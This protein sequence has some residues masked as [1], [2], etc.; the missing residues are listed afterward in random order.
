MPRPDQ[1]CPARAYHDGIHKRFRQI[2]TH[3]EATPWD[4]ADQSTG[5]G[6]PVL[7]ASKRRSTLQQPSYGDVAQQTKMSWLTFLMTSLL[8]YQEEGVSE[9]LSKDHLCTSSHLCNTCSSRAWTTLPFTFDGRMDGQTDRRTKTCHVKKW[10]VVRPGVS[11]FLVCDQRLCLR[12]TWYHL[13]W[14]TRARDAVVRTYASNFYM[15]EELLNT[16]TKEC[17]WT[18]LYILNIYT[19]VTLFIITMSNGRMFPVT[20]VR[21]RRHTDILFPSFVA[22]SHCPNCL[23]LC[24]DENELMK[25]TKMVS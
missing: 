15:H 4:Q 18:R 25:T 13:P 8:F 22:E 23:I 14:H 20:H 2:P 1:R 7:Q 10:G 24:Q 6:V 19:Y 17:L 12:I 9:T 11:D 3:A 21:S 5:R 16:Q